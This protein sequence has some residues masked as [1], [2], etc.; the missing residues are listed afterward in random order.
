MEAICSSE[1]SIFF[2]WTTWRYIQKTE[3]FTLVYIQVLGTTVLVLNTEIW[4]YMGDTI[5]RKGSDKEFIINSQ[6]TTVII[7]KFTV[8]LSSRNGI[9]EKL[10]QYLPVYNQQPNF[11]MLN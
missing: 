5:R 1:T 7:K 2:H 9:C 11:E 6:C 4:L 10:T 8:E 3:H